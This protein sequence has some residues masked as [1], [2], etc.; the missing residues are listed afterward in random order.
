MKKSI[1]INVKIILEATQFCIAFTG[2]F[3][4]FSFFKSAIPPQFERLA[5]GT[6][7]TI[8]AFLTSYLFLKFDKKTF[9]DIG[10][11]IEKTTLQ[12]FFMGLL[13][14]IA[15]MGTL[16]LGVIYFSNFSIEINKNSTFFNFFLCTLPLIPLAFME[17]MGFRGY[18]LVLLKNTIGMRQSV[19]ITAIVF[20]F[21]HIVNGWT[22]QTA[23]LGRVFGGLFMALPRSI[24]T[25]LRCQR[26]FIMLPI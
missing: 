10:L 19:S 16:S 8:A 9:A 14:G 17:E 5:H 26:D 23:F 18:P 15:L 6:I 7:G 24:Q 3:V 11:I 1:S 4:A 2:L 21:Y 20:G 25:V 12:N 13:I 22:F